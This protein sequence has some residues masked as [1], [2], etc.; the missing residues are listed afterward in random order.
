MGD[1][2]ISCA[3]K[4]E[5]DTERDILEFLEVIGALVDR[6]RTFLGSQ[7]RRKCSHPSKMK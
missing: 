3:E 7:G 2:M 6:W 4:M 1:I 5:I